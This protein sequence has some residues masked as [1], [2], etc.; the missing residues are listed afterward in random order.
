MYVK[1]HNS[2]FWISD[3]AEEALEKAIKK[4][5]GEV[6]KVWP[7]MTT[8]QRNASTTIIIAAYLRQTRTVT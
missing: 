7:E 4:L 5:E 1:I 2:N 6:E 8:E 3:K